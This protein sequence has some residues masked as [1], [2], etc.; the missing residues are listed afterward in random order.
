[1]KDKVLYSERLQ[2]LSNSTLIFENK[3]ILP[4]SLPLQYQ[5]IEYLWKADL[6]QIRLINLAGYQII[7]KNTGNIRRLHL[8]MLIVNSIFKTAN[9][10]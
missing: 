6:L 2:Q 1:M 3:T 5:I 8:P 4:I 7:D 10:T 9:I